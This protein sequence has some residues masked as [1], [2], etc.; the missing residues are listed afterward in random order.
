MIIRPRIV[1]TMHGSPIENGA[2]AINGQL[3]TDVGRFS[4]IKARNRGEVLDLDDQILLPGLINAHCHLDYTCLRGRILRHGCFSDWIRAINAA[5]SKLS[6][7]DYVISIREG[8]AEA[9]RYGTTTIANLT[10]HPELISQLDSPI[11]TWW[12]AELID[13]REPH[14]AKAIVDQAI[15][16]LEGIQNG[17]LAPHAPYTASAKMYRYSAELAQRHNLLLTT[18]LAESSEEAQMFLDLRGPLKDFLFHIGRDMSDLD[19]MT[20]VEHFLGFC[21][22]NERWLLVHL[23][24]VFFRDFEL[25]TRPKTK[26]HVVHCPRSHKYFGHSRFPLQRLRELGFNICIATDSLA[27]NDDLS[28][29]AELR[30]LQKYESTLS[31][32]EMIEMITLNPARALGLEQRLGRIAPGF[33]ADLV[34]IPRTSTNNVFLDIL[35]WGGSVS[36]AMIDGRVS[37]F[38]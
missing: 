27:S 37:D 3:I 24:E 17:G 21:P 30:T 32:R 26:P 8:F 1:V 2:V 25:L 18:H 16:A 31:P 33:L 23:N 29:L 20:P 15:K 6:A 11:R 36:W 19:G 28:L 9:R 35:N 4:E 12:F 38:A 34:A 22:L 7:N 14:R 13:V 10:A 5:K